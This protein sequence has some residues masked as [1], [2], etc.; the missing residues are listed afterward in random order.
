[1]ELKDFIKVGGYVK[2]K[3]THKLTYGKDLQ[4]E[5]K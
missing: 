1:M 5:V 3:T 4:G 2:M